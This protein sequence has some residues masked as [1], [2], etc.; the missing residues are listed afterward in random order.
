MTTEK[1]KLFIDTDV[2]TDCDDAFALTYALKNPRAEVLAIST[3]Q[4]RF[5]YRA[6]IAKKIAR[7]CNKEVPIIRGSLGQDKWWTGIENKVMTAQELMEP[8]EELKFPEYTGDTKLVCLGPLTNVANQLKSNP[9]IKNIKDIYVM[10]SSDE[11]HN[12]VVDLDATREVFNQDWNIY[13]I[14]KATSSK[15]LFQKD[16]LSNF[17]NNPLEQFLKTSMQNWME[18]NHKTY[19]LMYD[20]LA[21][22]AALDENYVNFNQVDKNHFVS[23]D[24]D[25]KLKS[26]LMEIIKNAS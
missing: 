20:V 21:V 16:E 19:S 7:L 6:K 24:V 8:L 18:F 1:I 14:T 13:Q 15:I 5:N 2:G 10:G 11:S 4:E 12:F 22:S 23:A 17:A 3:V 26:K 9:S 25:L